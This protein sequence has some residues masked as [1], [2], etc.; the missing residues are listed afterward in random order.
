MSDGEASNF[1]SLRYL[2]KINAFQTLI[3]C[4]KKRKGTFIQNNKCVGQDFIASHCRSLFIP[5][6]VKKKKL[7]KKVV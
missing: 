2:G 4:T 1:L 5:S 7:N 3:H 6:V